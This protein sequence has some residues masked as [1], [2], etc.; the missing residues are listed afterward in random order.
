MVWRGP[1]RGIE[2]VPSRTRSQHSTTR[3]SR[4]RYLSAWDVTV[5]ATVITVMYYSA[6]SMVSFLWHVKIRSVCLLLYIYIRPLSSVQNKLRFILY[7]PH[8]LSRSLVKHAIFVAVMNGDIK[9]ESHRFLCCVSTFYVYMSKCCFIDFKSKH[10]ERLI[11]DR[12]FVRVF[13]RLLNFPNPDNPYCTIQV[14]SVM[15]TVTFTSY[16]R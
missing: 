5:H 2:P 4:R 9:V 13:L 6:D 8:D 3:L 11:F 12:L 15:M 16:F 14:S 10:K 7:E 1:C